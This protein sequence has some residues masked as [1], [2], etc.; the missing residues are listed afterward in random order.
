MSFD[1]RK[2]DQE[3]VKEK[4]YRIPLQVPK[5][6]KEPIKEKAKEDGYNSITAWIKNMIENKLSENGEAAEKN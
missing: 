5:D 6:W 3:Y 2:Y 4:Y 1:K